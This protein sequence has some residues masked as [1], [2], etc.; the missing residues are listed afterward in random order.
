MKN[1]NE[2]SILIDIEITAKNG[3]E[4]TR[5]IS[6]SLK[7]TKADAGRGGYHPNVDLY[8]DASEEHDYPKIHASIVQPTPEW[9]NP[10][11]ND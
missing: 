1:Q 9:S 2:E 6:A 8:I 5:A 3:E 4:I 10:F 7:L 11:F